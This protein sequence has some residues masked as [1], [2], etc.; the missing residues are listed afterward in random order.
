MKKGWIIALV[1]ALLATLSTFPGCADL[2]AGD[3]GFN[4]IFRYGVGA[5]NE[6]NTYK[7]TYTKDMINAAPITVVFPLTA[8]EMAQIRQKMEEI[9]FFSYP[10]EFTVSVP[11]E[12]TVTRVTPNDSY[13]FKV[14]YGAQVKELKWDA[15]IL[16]RDERADK[17]KELIKLITGIIE[18]KPAYRGLPPPKGGYL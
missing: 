5:R 8:E 13:S 18:S 7:G 11:P 16:N 10:D 9:D 6:L 15:A 2:K 1:L 14:A 17:L 4:F 3:S 12:G